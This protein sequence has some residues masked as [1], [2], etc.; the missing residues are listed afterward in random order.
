M[1]ISQIN[2]ARDFLRDRYDEVMPYLRAKAPDVFDH[3][4]TLESFKRSCVTIT[5]KRAVQI[6]IEC[7]YSH[8]LI[9]L[10]GQAPHVRCTPVGR[11]CGEPNEIELTPIFDHRN[12][13]ESFKRSC[14]TTRNDDNPPDGPVPHHAKER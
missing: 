6:K 9:S 8:F 5:I 12:T 14:V 3:R 7:G 2:T 10:G 11:A 13:L 4:N 1:V